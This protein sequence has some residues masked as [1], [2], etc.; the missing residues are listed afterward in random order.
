VVIGAFLLFASITI[1][2]QLVFKVIILFF[3]DLLTLGIETLFSRCAT[4]AVS[5]HTTF[6]GSS[7]A[8]AVDENPLEKTTKVETI[9]TDFVITLMAKV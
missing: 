7:T 4:A 5:L 9:A 2:P 3:E 8:L 1:F 6:A